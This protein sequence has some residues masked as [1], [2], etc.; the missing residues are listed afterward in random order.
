MLCGRNKAWQRFGFARRSDKRAQQ[1]NHEAGLESIRDLDVAHNFD[2][3]YQRYFPDHIK[4]AQ[5]PAGVFKIDDTVIERAKKFFEK[6]NI[7]YI[8]PENPPT[9]FLP[10]THEFEVFLRDAEMF[11]RDHEEAITLNKEEDT[12]EEND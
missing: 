7:R 12:D 1:T 10:L 8:D 9:E 6:K 4:F 5:V 3:K 2:P 11:T